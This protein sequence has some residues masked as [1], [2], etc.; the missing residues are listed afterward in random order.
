MASAAFS[1]RLTKTCCIWLGSASTGG[2]SS[3]RSSVDGD[4]AELQLIHHDRDGA[5]RHVVQVRGLPARRRLAG[6]VEQAADDLAAALG[7]AHDHLEVGAQLGVVLGA[8]DEERGVGEHAGQRVVDLVRHAGREAADGCQLVGL[9]ELALGL[10]EPRRHRVEGARQLAELVA[11]GHRDGGGEI[12][13]GD[14]PR[15]R[16]QRFAPDG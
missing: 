13:G 9:R 1:T 2:R 7:L 14:A 15:A 3:A 10:G 12:A 5:P 6:E 16:C 8:V 4:V 11:A